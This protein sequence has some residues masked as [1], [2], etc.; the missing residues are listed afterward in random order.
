MCGIAGFFA[1]GPIRHRGPG[2]YN[3]QADF[4]GEIKCVRAA[5]VP[6]TAPGSLRLYFKFGYVPDPMPLSARCPRRDVVSTRLRRPLM[7]EL[8]FGERPSPA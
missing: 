6:L 1:L 5:G 8:W 7:L 4:S 3:L 2:R